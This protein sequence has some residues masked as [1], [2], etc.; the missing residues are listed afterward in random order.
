MGHMPGVGRSNLNIGG[1]LADFDRRNRILP[2]L[3]GV[4]EPIWPTWIR[5][6]GAAAPNTERGTIWGTAS[7]EASA[8]AVFMNRRRLP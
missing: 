4:Q 1:A 5:L 8:A 6:L 3:D 7:D 2:A